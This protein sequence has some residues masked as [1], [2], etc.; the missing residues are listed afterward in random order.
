MRRSR[1]GARTN[2]SSPPRPRPPLRRYHT[3]AFRAAQGAHV[4]GS[5]NA[6]AEAVFD[7][8]SMLFANQGDFY[9]AALNT[10]WVDAHIAALVSSNLG[11][12]AAAV[13]AGLADDNL[14]EAT[15]VSWKYGTSRYTTGTPH[16]LVNGI[17]VD[18]QIDGTLASWETLIDS[19]L[20]G[21]R[22]AR[23]VSPTL[24]RFE[25]L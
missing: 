8:A 3:F 22:K 19:L 13:A 25:A 11:Y 4:V 2:A 10:T 21:T 1:A 16:Y 9:G 15:R 5:L 14:N 17:P 18:D 7:Y 24:K 12:S 20:T 6:S 23:P